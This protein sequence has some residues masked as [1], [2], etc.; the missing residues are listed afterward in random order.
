MAENTFTKPTPGETLDGAIQI[1]EWELGGIPV[2]FA[3]LYVGSQLGGSEY[4]AR[5]VGA[6]TVTSIGH[7]PTDGSAVFVRLWYRTG[8]Q[9]LFFDERYIAASSSSL[10]FIVE[11]TPGATLAGRNQTFSWDFDGGAVDGSWLYVGSSTG[12]SDIVATPTGTSTSTTISG[13]PTDG[14]TVHTRLYFK[15][16]GAWYYVDDTFVAAMVPRPTRDELTRELQGLVGVT[17]DGI[18][19]PN[20]RAALNR[21]WLGRVDGFDPSFAERFTNGP[22]VVRWVQRRINT[23]T[24]SELDLDGQYG[25]ATESAV[26]DELGKSGVVAAESFVALLDP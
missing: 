4:A 2:E 12:G 7:L 16:G 24:G 5:Q 23:R 18:V 1:F 22:D 17:Q 9:W 11:P 20:T 8:G 10:P 13:L 25:P 15:I 19:G 6:A 21:N 3:W 26:A 14:R